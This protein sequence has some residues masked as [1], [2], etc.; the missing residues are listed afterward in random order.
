M[1]LLRFLLFPFAVLYDLITTI[2]NW[3]FELGLLKSTSFD[4]PVIVVGNLSVG[5]TGKSPQIEYLIRLLKDTHK[6][7]VLSRGY[8]RKTTGFQIVNIKHSAAD[9]GDEPLQFF[10][11]FGKE[12]TVVVDAD[13]TNGIQ[14]LLKSDVSP[15]V[16]L[17]DDAYQHRKVKGS[18]YILLTK[19]DD[20]Y[21]DD[22]ILPTG[23][24]R[25]S[26]RGAKRAAII[27]VTKCP[28]NLSEVAKEKI[29]TKINLSK[30]QQLFFTTISY[31]ENLK[32]AESE[33]T[34]ADLKHKD[35][36][37]VTGIAKPS[38]LLSFL[39]KENINYK[40]LEYADHYDFNA[41]DI[42]K[43][44]KTFN[45]LPSE[46]KIILTTEK[47]YMRLNGKID[48]LCY[49]T[50]KSTFLSDGEKFNQFVVNHVK[51]NIK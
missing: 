19:Y 36:L 30:N 3:F 47:D 21:V 37:L 31:D 18:S 24:L 8:K 2:R 20:L 38:S 15:Q 43:I 9:V 42:L 17:L 11:K 33:L 10:K 46:N 39:S 45:D 49:I 16:V 41:Q 48:N 12:V 7:A 32:G 44:E 26:R 50:I 13:R 34:I 1:K 40:H 14:Q 25:E 4:I 51:N 29:K 27:I 35:V 22:F 23:N 28:E 5:G 6:V